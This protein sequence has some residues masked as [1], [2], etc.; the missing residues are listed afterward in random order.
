VTERATLPEPLAPGRRLA[1]RYTLERPLGA[2]GMAS[3]WLASDGVLERQVAAKI[4]A[5][6]FAGEDGWLRRF[7]REA[8]AIAALNHPNVVRVFDLGE[9]G[10][11]P[12]IVMQYVAGGSLAERL[13][14]TGPRLAQ[15]DARRIAADLL[16]GVAR[17][18]A[19]GLLHRDIKP[20]NILI[21]D[22]GV[23]MLSDFGAVLIPDAT[24]LTGI[25][26]VI[27]TARYMAPELLR[28]E[29]ATVA[30][31]LFAC[32]CVIGDATRALGED[33]GL[34]ALVAELT[35]FDAADRPRSAKAALR[36]LE[37]SD[38]A[39][40]KP[41]GALPGRGRAERPARDPRTAATRPRSR[42]RT[43]R[44]APPRSGARGRGAPAAAI[45][46]HGRRPRALPLALLAAAVLVAV[47]LALALGGGG[48]PARARLPSPAPRSAA[49]QAQL[50][51]LRREVR[52]ASTR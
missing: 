40:G 42:R 14:A 48:A 6:A 13:R 22:G 47:V 8:R 3:V 9:D 28:G 1:G 44:R 23:A 21:G 5:E 12:F 34:S 24:Q 26:E 33:P 35:A 32:G 25:G 7:R 18:H 16:C 15:L 29:P 4:I 36:A 31:D 17:I 52:A 20:G 50:S 43:A 27:G 37:E 51:A 45:W 38:R 2:G 11:R 19:D 39:P 49:L 10:G 46:R 30:A 41:R